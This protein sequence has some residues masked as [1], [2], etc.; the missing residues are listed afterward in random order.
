MT[1]IAKNDTF[2]KLALIVVVTIHLSIVSG[3]VG[4]FI[5]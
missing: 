5:A 3:L 1:R 2:G 4:A